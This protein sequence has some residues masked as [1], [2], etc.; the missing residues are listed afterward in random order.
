MTRTAVRT[1]EHDIAQERTERPHA[2]EVSRDVVRSPDG[3]IA[4][5][6]RDGELLSRKAPE[7]TD[8]FHFDKNEIPE[9]YGYQWIRVTT[10]NEADNNNVRQYMNN[11]WR[12]VPADRHPDR[13]DAD[14][15]G[16]IVFKGNM[17]VERPDALNQESRMEEARKAQGQISDQ[18]RQFGHKM[19]GGFTANAPNAR[20]ASFINRS[21]ERGIPA[22]PLPIDN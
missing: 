2:R 7:N 15:K 3:R 16:H 20:N 8:P 13:F 5:Y 11:G 12:P 9:G 1:K 6:G 4:V 14:D 19:E 21:F 22:A 10:Y 17:L 18:Y